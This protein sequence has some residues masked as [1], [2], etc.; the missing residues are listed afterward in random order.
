MNSK[1]KQVIKNDDNVIRIKDYLQL[2]IVPIILIFFFRTPIIYEPILNYL[3]VNKTKGVITNE[4]NYKR[5]AH[6]TNKFSYS[7]EFYYEG[8]KYTND[9]KREYLRVGDSIDV[10]FNSSF[11]FI[12]KIVD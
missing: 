3:K 11:P 8:K 5:R 10:V 7:Y 1:R 9:S 6:F 2:L 4:K 12:N